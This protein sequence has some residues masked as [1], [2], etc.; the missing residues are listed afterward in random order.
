MTDW[1]SKYLEMKLKYINAKNKSQN[2]I[3]N[4]GAYPFELNQ[5]LY[6]LMML[7]N[8]AMLACNKARLFFGIQP[9][10]DLHI[11]LYNFYVNCESNTHWYYTYKIL[12]QYFYYELDKIYAETV[13][14]H[15]NRLKFMG[16]DIFGGGFEQ[17][18]EAKFDNSFFVLK[19]HMHIEVLNMFRRR[20][21]E[22]IMNVIS[23]N[24]R[25]SV[26]IRNYFDGVDTIFNIF[27]TRSNSQ[28]GRYDIIAETEF[29]HPIENYVPHV[30]V[31][32]MKELRARVSSSIY[33]SVKDKYIQGDTKGAADFLS[34]CFSHTDQEQYIA[35]LLPQSHLNTFKVNPR[36]VGCQ[37]EPG[38]DVEH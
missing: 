9:T 11:T 22:A 7:T 32:T 15:N 34:K 12:T 28:H 29:M 24:L 31:F 26:Q 27:R 1:K 16:Y 21:Y 2:Y 30:S 23:E 18:I 38:I 6:L 8:E 3:Q 20:V 35:R 10:A 17:T 19:Y 13:L 4:G 25:P 5:N 37:P 14:H 36:G 33:K